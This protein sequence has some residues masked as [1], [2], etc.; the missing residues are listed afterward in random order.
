MIFVW[1]WCTLE[2]DFCGARF[3]HSQETDPITEGPDVL[4]YANES[5]FMIPP[6]TWDVDDPYGLR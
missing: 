5:C 1:Y 6:Y 2:S 3:S 4:V